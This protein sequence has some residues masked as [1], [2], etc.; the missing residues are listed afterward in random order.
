MHVH[1]DFSALLLL[2]DGVQVRIE[3][4]VHGE[5]VDA[6]LLEDSA[7]GIV[8]ADLAL[9]VG[10]LQVACFDVL[11]YLLDGLRS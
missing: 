8:A 3:D 2:V 11:P 4:L 10:V 5:H 6:V 9:V 7:H 1:D